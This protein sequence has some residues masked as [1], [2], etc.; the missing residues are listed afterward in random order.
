MKRKLTGGLAS[1]CCWLVEEP[2]EVCFLELECF[3]EDFYS[4]LDM[5]GM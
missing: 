2:G 3:R 5:Q 4:S 1:F